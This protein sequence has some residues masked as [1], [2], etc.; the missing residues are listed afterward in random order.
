[1]CL[2]LS[3]AAVFTQNKAI[4]MSLNQD[5][6]FCSLREQI[7]SDP[8]SWEYQQWSPRQEFWPV[9]WQGRLSG[10]GSLDPLGCG[11]NVTF[12]WLKIHLGPLST[13]MSFLLC[14]L[15][16]GWKLV[17]ELLRV[18]PFALAAQLFQSVPLGTAEVS[19]CPALWPAPAG[20]HSNSSAG[21]TLSVV[22]W[23]FLG[24]ENLFFQSL[25]C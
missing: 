19:L 21:R 2:H 15:S 11:I 10:S 7:H 22:T 18:W 25:L 5:T 13:E 4:Q 17:E 23:K 24:K 16:H 6:S 8:L 3:L 1:M 14:L 12:S 20:G 9:P